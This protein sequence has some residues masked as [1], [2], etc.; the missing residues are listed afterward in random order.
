MS[1][2]LLI[3]D[4]TLP[5]CVIAHSDPPAWPFDEKYTTIVPTASTLAKLDDVCWNT[6]PPLSPGRQIHVPPG[7]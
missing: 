3:T 5:I 4:S 1:R 7:L 6:G 2:E